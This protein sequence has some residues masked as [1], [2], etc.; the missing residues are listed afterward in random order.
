MAIYTLP[1]SSSLKDLYVNNLIADGDTINL[2]GFNLIVKDNCCAASEYLDRPNHYNFGVKLS[3]TG[4]LELMDG[5]GIKLNATLPTTINPWIDP[6][7]PLPVC[8]SG[9]SSTWPFPNDPY[10][11]TLTAN[12]RAEI[13]LAGNF[14]LGGGGARLPTETRV[15]NFYAHAVSYPT[16]SKVVFD[17]DLPLHVGDVLYRMTTLGSDQ[18]SFSVIGLDEQTGA[19]VV[20]GSYPTTDNSELFGVLAGGV[21]IRVASNMTRD[22]IGSDAKGGTINVLH[23]STSFK[24]CGDSV[25]LFFD[26]FA[27]GGHPGVNLNKTNTQS[28][29]GFGAY[30]RYE[31]GKLI[32][33]ELYHGSNGDGR[34]CLVAQDAAIFRPIWNYASTSVPYSDSSK[35]IIHRGEIGRAFVAVPRNCLDI[36]LVLE[37]VTAPIGFE[38]GIFGVA[39]LKNCNIPNAPTGDVIFGT[40]GSV[41]LQGDKSF[42][43]NPA[44]ST[45]VTWRYTDNLIQPNSTLRINCKWATDSQTS[46]A[47]VAIT[48]QATWWPQLWKLG[49]EPLAKVEFDSST[50]NEQIKI[51]SYRNTSDEPMQVRVWECVTGNTDGGYLSTKVVRGGPM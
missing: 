23:A 5:G 10:R 38:Q 41:T 25:N 33:L 31:F 47:S 18:W 19:W 29:W 3:G 6:E 51:L 46:L 49:V 34:F 27:E 44:T 8:Y 2:G 24:M 21:V 45:D 17:R 20:D 39:H 28:G 30:G 43:H 7:H 42:Y 32:A 26:K 35:V 9:D 14:G 12:A 16:A 1:E 50:P 15:G 37:N 40:N 11:T 22:L 13:Q 4:K 48:N 36:S